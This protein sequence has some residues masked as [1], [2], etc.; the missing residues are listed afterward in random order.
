MSEAAFHELE[1]LSPD[2]K[3]EYLNGVAYLM[4]A[5]SS[6]WSWGDG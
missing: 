1:R 3:Y 2:R 6:L 4:L 5:L